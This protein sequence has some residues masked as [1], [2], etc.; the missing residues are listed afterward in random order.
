M[1]KR[2]IY[3][4]CFFFIY[5]IASAFAGRVINVSP[6][7]DRLF[8]KSISKYLNVYIDSSQS[9]SIESISSYIDRFERWK[10]DNVHLGTNQNPIW[11]YT[12]INNQ[13]NEDVILQIGYPILDTISFYLVRNGVVVKEF[14]TGSSFEFEKREILGNYFKFIIPPGQ[15]QVFFRVRSFYNVQFPATLYAW[16]SLNY[17]NSKEALLQGIYIGFVVIIVL[18]NLFFYLS[19]RDSIYIWYILHVAATA[20]IT[21]HL[22]GYTF[23]YLWPKLPIINQNEPIIYGLGI[24]TTLFSI[25]FLRPETF[26]RFWNKVLW[27]IFWLNVPVFILPFVGEKLLANMVVQLVGSFG[28]FL[29]LVAGFALMLRGYRPAVFYVIAFSF[30]LVGVILSIMARMNILPNI[31]VFVHASQI[32]SALDMIMLSLAV[33]DRVNEGLRER[34]KLKNQLL[35]EAVEKE[36]IIRQQNLML[37][38]EVDR[39]TSDLKKANTA[40]EKAAQELKAKNEYQNKLLTIVGQ[41]LKGSLANV[42]GL[43]EIYRDKP[44]TIDRDTFDLMYTSALNTTSILQNLLVFAQ[45]NNSDLRPGKFVFNLY[46]LISRVISQIRPQAYNKHIDLSIDCA[47]E[48]EI[49]AD[50]FYL[51]VVLRNLLANAIKFTPQGGK[52]KVQVKELPSGQ[53]ELSVQDTGVGM[54]AERVEKF[55]SKNG[56]FTTVGTSGERGTGIGRILIKEL[57]DAMKG[58]V[59]IASE[60]GKGTTFTLTFNRANSG[61]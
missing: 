20:I 43:L 32:G 12:D 37:K 30:L 31:P 8:E 10:K 28:C 15:N 7:I 18:Y 34:K 26:S 2:R 40:L 52:I 21:L 44:E 36:N 27:G 24:F 22:N 60:L 5:F 53:I 3:Y 61:K 59:S 25:K 45:I 55:F 13:S 51:E 46:T 6:G 35:K 56:D 14:T 57:V 48:T 33:A 50:E 16:K 29:M 23:K 41:D 19:I 17:E 49:S 54:S 58:T 4:S 9:L 42:T 38:D 39:Q 11:F 1:I 47:K